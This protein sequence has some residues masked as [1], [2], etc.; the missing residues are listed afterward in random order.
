MGTLSNNQILVE[1]TNII[2]ILANDK[3]KLSRKEE[4]A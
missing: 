2:E 3:N 1:K 4:F